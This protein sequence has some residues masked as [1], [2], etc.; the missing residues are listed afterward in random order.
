MQDLEQ[1]QW[2]ETA[3]EANDWDTQ[4]F[5]GGALAATTFLTYF[6][7]SLPAGLL[8]GG[9]L[10]F[11]GLRKT[12]EISFRDDLIN[13]GV[14]AH[15][16][17]EEDLRKYEARYG[18]ESVLN[19]VQTALNE[20]HRTSSHSE[21]LLNTYT[22]H[23]NEVNE[24]DDTAWVQ[25]LI[26][27]T[28]L[29]WGNMGGGKSWLT[30]YVVKMKKDAGYRVVVLDPDGNKSSWSGVESYHE[31]E[32]IE[33]QIRAYV[34][35]L[36]KRL[37]DF[38]KSDKTEEEWQ[39]GLQPFAL[40]CE[41][42]TTYGDF[43]KDKALLEKFGKLALTKSRKPLMPL[44]VVAHNN[45]QTCLFGIKGL[46]NLVSKM[47][48]VECLAEVDRNTLQPRSTGTALVKLDSSNEKILKTLP[49]MT[50]KIIKF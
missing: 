47:L 45:T 20:G 16:L 44:T 40:I 48:Q 37:S 13:R 25:N 15:V 49:K 38:I 2:K 33:A 4:I 30:R 32:D 29:V 17:K 3:Y 35:E 27:Q 34:E 12:D 46:Y 8:A 9:C 7:S 18:L 26:K 19:Q 14:V 21:D 39:A 41:E 10:W 1:L 5:V 31:W 50:E 43:I 11:Y 24:V 6:T 28:A 22:P 23:V 36:E 42:A